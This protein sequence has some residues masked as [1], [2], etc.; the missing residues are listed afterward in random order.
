MANPVKRKEI[1][2]ILE[3]IEV[4]ER[5]SSQLAEIIE[6]GKITLQ[7]PSGKATNLAR[8]PLGKV[9]DFSS[10]LFKS[11]NVMK[12]SC[13]IIIEDKKKQIKDLL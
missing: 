8:G 12:L 1:N 11:L 6:S 7:T 3:Q 10:S 2:D 9:R 5:F 4:I 13:D